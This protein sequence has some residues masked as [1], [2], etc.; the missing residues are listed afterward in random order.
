MNTYPAEEMTFI[1]QFL[2]ITAT[3]QSVVR[4]DSFPTRESVKYQARSSDGNMK[5]NSKESKMQETI[6]YLM[7][8]LDELDVK[9][10]YQTE[11]SLE[12]LANESQESSPQVPKYIV[13][14]QEK[15][16][17]FTDPIEYSSESEGLAGEDNSKEDEGAILQKYIDL[18]KKHTNNPPGWKRAIEEKGYKQMQQPKLNTRAE[19]M[20]SN[21]DDSA[22]SYKPEEGLD[23]LIK[24]LRA[25][26]K[27][28][29]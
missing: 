2:L 12:R 3:L 18:A 1:I 21:S 9:A 19:P 14:K 29:Q 4:V 11:T 7:S 8:H 28:K 20:A 13:T 23:E 5:T 16:Y 24:T 6:D 27:D 10:V 25:Y 22:D 15:V 17:I 26:I